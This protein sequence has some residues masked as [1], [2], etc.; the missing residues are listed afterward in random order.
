MHEKTGKPEEY[1][2]KCLWEDVKADTIMEEVYPNIR[3]LLRL[4]MLFPLSAAVVER[5]F[6]KLKIVKN[7]LRNRLG[8]LTLSKLLTVCTELPKDG[9]SDQD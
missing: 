7:R 1:D 4:L 3:V 2:T 6:S 8:D 5:L 9:F